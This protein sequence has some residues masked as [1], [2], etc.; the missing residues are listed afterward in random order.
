MKIFNGGSNPYR[1]TGMRPKLENNCIHIVVSDE[2]LKRFYYVRINMSSNVTSV[3][4]EPIHNA[5]IILSSK[6]ISDANNPHESCFSVGM[7]EDNNG[8]LRGILIP[9]INP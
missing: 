7:E 4:L 1:I 5:K 9:A 6:W 2:T 3:T 8:T